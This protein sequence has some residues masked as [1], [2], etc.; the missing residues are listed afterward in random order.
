M[1]RRLW[2]TSGRTTRRSTSLHG[3]ASPRARAEQDDAH[4][5][6]PFNDAL[7][8]SV[9]DISAQRCC[10]NHSRLPLNSSQNPGIQL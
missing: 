5:M 2:A 6:K 4:G 1:A 9:N 8:D 3:P 7:D 10:M